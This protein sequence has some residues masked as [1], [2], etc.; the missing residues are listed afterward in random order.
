VNEKLKPLHGMRFKLERRCDKKPPCCGYEFGIVHVTEH[1]AE[2][3]CADC[4]GMRGEN[5]T[6]VD[7]PGRR[8]GSK[9]RLTGKFIAALAK[10]FEE[11]GEAA[12]RI[13]R[14]EEPATFLKLIAHLV[15]KEFTFETATDDLSNEELELMIVRL[16]AEIAEDAK[17]PMLI[18]AKLIEV[19]K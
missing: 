19:E 12:I 10:E 15:P 4:G 6:F 16:R 13:V 7:S 8:R 18:E 14:V 11:H 5:G 17:K 2:I 1:A 9:N 3:W